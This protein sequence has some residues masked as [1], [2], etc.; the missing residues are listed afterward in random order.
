[1]IS[2][3]NA[4]ST[5]GFMGKYC[6]IDLSTGKTEDVKPGEEFYKKYLSG[7]GLGAAVISERQKP[8]IDALGPE[9]HLG[10]CSGLLTGTGAYFSGRFM[11]VGKSPLTGGWGDA[12]SGGSF[13][14][15]LKRT[16]YDAVFFTGIPDK[17]VWVY[18]DDSGIEIRDAIDLWGMDTVE[19]EEYIRNEIG[20]K[21]VQVACIGQ[22]GEKLSRISGIVTDGGRIAAR[23]GLGAVM[24]S[25]KLK[26]L[27]VR[28]NINVSVVDTDT[29]KKINSAFMKEF[30][31]S[32]AS[33]RLTVSLAN[34]VF[35]RFI[36][37]TGISVPAHASLFREILKKYGTAGN[38]AYSALIGDM[39]IRN[40][41]GVGYTDFTLDSASKISDES[42]VARQK[43]KYACQGCPIGCGGIIDIKSGRYAGSEGHKPEYESL[44]AF[45]GLLLHDDLDAIIEANELCN[46]AGIDTISTGGAIAFAIECLEK[47]ILSPSDFD[48]IEPGWGKSAEI[49]KLTE[50]IINREG[51]GDLLADGVRIASA[52]IGKGS[53]ACAVH[54]GGQELPMHDSRLD[55]GYAIAYQCEPTPGRHTISSYMYTGLF[56]TEKKFPRAKKMLRGAKGKDGKNVALYAASSFY[57]Q[58]MNGCGMCMFG[59]MTSDLPVVEYLNAV[60]GW[61][62]SADD[63]LTTGE[64]ILQVRKAFTAREGVRPADQR[65]NDRAI[66]TIPMT[67]GPLKGVTVDINGLQE[68]YFTLAGW[69]SA[70][71]GPT[72]EKMR[73]MGIE[74]LFPK[75]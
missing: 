30:K 74:S 61:D 28:G 75:N 19:T 23:S 48:G 49:I 25:K 1:M 52:K 51:I 73:E 6:I 69:D 17:P 26:A 11:V 7:Y 18:I 24:G 62:L 43:K 13:A 56:R 16:G 47:G 64:R 31:K 66:G 57:V 41:D 70:T 59:G 37:H 9:S 21:R 29:M 35:S 36:Y 58:L 54:A 55:P 22:S 4:G 63:Y 20:D 65:L 50:M 67:A 8:G 34:R 12:N 46:R 3:K 38:L 53:E 27:A 15:E 33:D 40:W 42:I 45:G 71:G 10:F 2:Q 14:R 5:G 44:G 72:E 60:T 68:R 32:S 39:P